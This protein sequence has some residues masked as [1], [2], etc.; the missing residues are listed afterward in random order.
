MGFED[1]G[2]EVRPSCA[3]LRQVLRIAGLRAGCGTIGSPG[4][5]G[6]GSA[7]IG[8][9]GN[10]GGTALLA[11]GCYTREAAGCSA[12]DSFAPTR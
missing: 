1:I 5:S 9:S 11:A 4:H 6:R 8:G 3:S 7:K 12:R 10:V 2:S